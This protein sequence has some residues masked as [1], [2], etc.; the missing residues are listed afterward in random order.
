MS[1]SERWFTMEN[2]PA[3]RRALSRLEKEL[4]ATL[5]FEHGGEY[6]ASPHWVTRILLGRLFQERLSLG[7]EVKSYAKF[8]CR[9]MMRGLVKLNEL[10]EAAEPLLG[11]NQ[12][13]SISRRPRDEAMDM[14]AEDV[15][16]KEAEEDPLFNP[17]EQRLGLL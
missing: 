1:P 11:D 5:L 13:R 6:R 4:E 3:E 2:S 16:L 8:Q 10:E 7:R 12:E 14:E 17:G 15:A 9:E